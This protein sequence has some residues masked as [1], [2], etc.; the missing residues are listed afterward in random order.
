MTSRKVI[1]WNAIAPLFHSGMRLI[2]G[3][4]MGIGTPRGPVA[5]ILGA[6]VTGLTFIGNDSGLPETGVGPLI[7]QR[8]VKRLLPRIAPPNA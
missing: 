8:R 5:A 6:G 4:F 7:A 3:G 1:Q 2:F